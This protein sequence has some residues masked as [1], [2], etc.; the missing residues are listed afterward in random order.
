MSSRASLVLA[1]EY[2]IFGNNYD[3]ELCVTLNLTEGQ[4]SFYAVLLLLSRRASS[5]KNEGKHAL[6]NI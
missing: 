6:H 1:H 2:G 5:Q 3:T 4:R